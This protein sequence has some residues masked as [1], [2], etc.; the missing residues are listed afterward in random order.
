MDDA[1]DEG[2]G[3]FLLDFLRVAS[4]RPDADQPEPVSS[5]AECEP[6]PAENVPEGGESATLSWER[7]VAESSPP[8]S[9]A[10]SA[11]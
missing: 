4:S 5:A 11:S 2:T 3:L 8:S 10:K 1:A 7:D 9:S 6:A